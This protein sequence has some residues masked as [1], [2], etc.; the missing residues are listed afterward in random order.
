[1]NRAQKRTQR[2]IRRAMKAKLEEAREH[3]Q[4]VVV[5]LNETRDERDH[6][7]EATIDLNKEIDRLKGRP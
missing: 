6:Y 7:Q 4:A 2:R 5:I 3:Y 1:M